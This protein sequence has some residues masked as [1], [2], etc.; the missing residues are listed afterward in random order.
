[1][2]Q[3]SMG[4]LLMDHNEIRHAL[5]EYLDGSL[6]PA[7]RAIVEEHLKSCASCAD[8]LAEL[9]K[10]IEQIKS[11]EQVEPPAWMTKKI[12]TKVREEDGKKKS[13]WR[14]WFFPFRF[15]IETVGVVL[16]AVT[17]FFIYKNT[18]PVD[19][20]AEQPLIRTE[21]LKRPPALK[22]EPAKDSATP[23]PRAVPQAPGYK[24]LDM[25]QEYESPPPPVP[26]QA[27]AAAAEPAAGS[28]PEKKIG[29]ATVES[30][31]AVVQERSEGFALAKE[32]KRKQTGPPPEGYA[33]QGGVKQLNCLEYGPQVVELSGTIHEQDFPRPPNY[34]SIA[35]GD[36]RETS[37]IL[38]LDKV[39]CVSGDPNDALNQAEKNIGEIQLVIASEQYKKYKILLLKPVTVRGTI[40]H[41]HTVHHHTRIL[42]NVEQILPR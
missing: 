3:E 39:I 7:D 36:A 21:A 41:S 27:P 34:E 1:M 11:L 24:A 14:Y 37:W 42:L 40:F 25:K 33:V 28:A 35:A 32:T 10:T 18:Q 23:V 20:V 22:K 29:A 31:N 19:R 30:R 17:A 12:M 26:E 4:E 15:P 38:H 8:A 2:P 13:I 5:S 9:R 16:L 6:P